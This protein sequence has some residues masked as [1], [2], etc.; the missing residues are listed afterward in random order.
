MGCVLE[1]K[2]L[3]KNIYQLPGASIWTF[4]NGVCKSK[5]KYF[6]QECWEKQ[7]L[8]EKEAFY[9][10]YANSFKSVLP[11]Y[12]NSTDQIAMSLT[13]GLD[14]RMIMA[15]NQRPRGAFPCY[16][17][18]SMYHDSFDVKI[19]RKVAR[20]CGQE[21]LTIRVDKNFIEDFDR[22][23]E[24]TVYITDGYL[25]VTGA[26]ELYVNKIAREVAPI[27]ITGNYGSEVLRGI[28]AFKP[29]PTNLGFFNHDFIKHINQASDLFDESVKMHDLSFAVFKQAPWF[30]YNR[31]SIEQS[32][33]TMRSPFM[34]NELLALAF[35]NPK[36]ATSSDELTH[37]LISNG[38]FNLHY[39]LTNRSVTIDSNSFP[40]QARKVW[41]EFLRL[42][43][44][45]Y[46]YGMPQ[47]FASIDY[48][49][50]SLHPERVLLGR[51]KFYHFRVWYR[52]ELA[53]YVSG[54]LLDSSTL[55]RSYFN[56]RTISQMVM[57]HISGH[58]NY[59]TEI[60]RLLTVELIHRLF[61]V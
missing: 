4:S 11:R 28:R 1:D 36:N 53:D 13:G 34:D 44:Y 37:R 33:L 18:G 38:N 6:D 8:L 54:I 48:L 30:N 17:F 46:D 2:T 9:I 41:W 51:H 15:N 55:N 35:R 61:I 39:I 42:S 10:E 25:D 27:R 56:K 21:H 31:L 16:T 12:L 43:E 58:R 3:F 7:T 5:V 23:A 20:A 19:A 29:K 52:D 59:T 26:I 45:C 60:T 14:T 24:K 50:K 49:I 22:L 47:W 40:F 32:Q 57:S